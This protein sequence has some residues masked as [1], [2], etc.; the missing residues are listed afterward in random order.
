MQT[1]C[2]HCG[3]Q[4]LLNDEVLAK[5]TKVQFRC[6]KCGKTTIVEVKRQVDETMAISPMPS[7]ART[8]AE[9]ARQNLPP[10]D[11]GLS[12]PADVDVLLTVTAGPDAGRSEVLQKARVV[13][14]RKGA[15]FALNDPEISRHHCVLEFREQFVNLKDLDSTNGTFLEEERVRA[16]VLHDGSEF[17]VGSSVIRLNFRKK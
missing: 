1:G 6:T 11:E 14:G 3:Q 2:I 5:H 9:P 4:H 7:F 15:E 17:R 8:D 16:A 10:A 13:V 12:L